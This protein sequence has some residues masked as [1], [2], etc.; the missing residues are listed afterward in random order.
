MLPKFNSQM[1]IF[2]QGRKQRTYQKIKKLCEGGIFPP[3]VFTLHYSSCYW[4]QPELLT[5]HLNL[6]SGGAAWEVQRTLGWEGTAKPAETC[7]LNQEVAAVGC[8]S[9]SFWARGIRGSQLAS[10]EGLAT[11]SVLNPFR[12]SCAISGGLRGWVTCV[13]KRNLALNPVEQDVSFGTRRKRVCAACPLAL[14]CL[15]MARKNT[16]K[17]NNLTTTQP[18]C[19]VLSG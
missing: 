17:K 4:W 6:Y 18:H 14:P 2:L 16:S 5:Q 8:S 15:E 1:N 12:V 19:G 7:L 9:S 13:F 10:P 11:E 3:R